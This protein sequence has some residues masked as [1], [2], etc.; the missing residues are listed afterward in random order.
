MYRDNRTVVYRASV[1]VGRGRLLLLDTC[2]RSRGLLSWLNARWR[3][4]NRLSLLDVPL[5]ISSIFLMHDWLP[6]T[7][8]SPVV[9]VSDPASAYVLA[10]E[11]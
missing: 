2:L 11:K 9:P 4:L 6:M 1:H 7:C 3:R 5:V 10:S 8:M